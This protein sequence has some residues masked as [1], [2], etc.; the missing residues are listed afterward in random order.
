MAGQVYYFTYLS[1]G[2]LLR[3]GAVTF[4]DTLPA[5]A[6]TDAEPPT[7]P[8]DTLVEA[9]S[10]CPAPQIS[11]SPVLL[12]HLLQNN[13]IYNCKDLGLANARV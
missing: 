3:A 12:S 8:K 6:T 9:E 1:R 7:G 4:A 13:L 2:V 11:M 5:S 10:I